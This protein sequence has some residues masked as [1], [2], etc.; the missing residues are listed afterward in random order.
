MINGISLSAPDHYV[1]TVS[2][3]CPVNYLAEYTMKLKTYNGNYPYKTTSDFTV[4]VSKPVPS[5]YTGPDAYGY[6]AYS[7]DDYFDQ[8][9][10]YSW[11]EINQIG[12]PLNMS[13]MGDYTETVNLPFTFKYYGIEYNQVRISTDG[14]IAFGSGSQ[15]APANY[16]LPH[17]DNISCMVAGF[18]DDL[19]DSETVEGNIYYYSDLANH[20]FIIEWD[21]IARNDFGSEPNVEIFQVVLY[22]VNYYPTT[23]G[24]GEIVIYY[25]QVMTPQFCT[26]GIENQAQNIGLQ[27]VYNN[28]YDPT[29]S[30]MTSGFAIKFTTE[31]PFSSIITSTGEQP[32][33]GQGYLL[34]Q[35]RPNPFSSQTWITYTIPEISH[36]T[37]SIYNVNGTLVRILQDSRQVSG[38]YTIRWDGL[39]AAGQPVSP[40]AYFYEITT[41]QFRDSKKMFILK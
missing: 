40:G 28:A 30:A 35:N 41:D 33:P 5:D 27:Y 23:T 31:P 6:Y 36:V 16:E 26:V 18:W 20:R 32:Q 29:A 3:D 11:F 8:A 37:L 2:P 10:D 21:S 14:W 25:K 38:S 13:G 9:P 7:S 39:N 24:D 19:Y 4:P 1:V 22:D 15:T 17:N 34:D 12:N